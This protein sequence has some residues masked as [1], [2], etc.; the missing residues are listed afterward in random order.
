MRTVFF[1]TT[2]TAEQRCC[3]CDEILAIYRQCFEIY[4][5]V[6]MYAAKHL[7]EE[8]NLIYHRLSFIKVLANFLGSI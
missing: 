8:K 1:A 6:R 4:R 3:G 2:Y 7:A 5:W